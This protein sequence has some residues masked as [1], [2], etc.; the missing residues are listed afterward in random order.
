MSNNTDGI[1]YTRKQEG[2]RVLIE[3][4]KNGEVIMG[5]NENDT[6]YA[7]VCKK[8][9]ECKHDKDLQLSIITPTYWGSRDYDQDIDCS[10]CHMRL[11]SLASDRRT[12]WEFKYKQ[13]PVRVDP[14]THPDRRLAQFVGVGLRDHL[15][16]MI[17]DCENELRLKNANINKEELK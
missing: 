8:R 1:K 2:D 4:W 16:S 13:N 3:I 9:A 6:H 10:E 12:I 11:Y 14:L 17:K 5:Y 15:K 7:Q